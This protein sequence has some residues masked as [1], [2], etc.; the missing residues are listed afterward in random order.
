MPK[1]YEMPVITPRNQ[2]TRIGIEKFKEYLNLE[3]DEA[4]Y[5][6]V[7]NSGANV[8]FKATDLLKLLN[9][10]HKEIKYRENVL[11]IPAL[12]LLEFIKG[13]QPRN[14]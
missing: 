13:R 2:A 3:N 14:K 1:I 9:I 5:T 6:A 8:V 12:E 7:K 4:I 11:N 10:Y